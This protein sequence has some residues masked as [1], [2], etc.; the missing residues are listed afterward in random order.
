[1]KKMKSG[2]PILFIVDEV[3]PFESYEHFLRKC[4]WGAEEFRIVAFTPTRPKSLSEN[5]KNR[6]VDAELNDIEKGRLDE[7]ATQLAKNFPFLESVKNKW[8]FNE[9]NLAG[10]VTHG[11]DYY[12]IH[13]L[14]QVLIIKKIIEKIKPAQVVLQFGSPL[15]G[16]FFSPLE[17]YYSRAAKAFCDLHKIPN[18]TMNL[19]PES[20]LSSYRSS[21]LERESA[22]SIR[23][24][25][26]VN[27]FIFK[28]QSK[29]FS[30]HNSP[31]V[32]VL[33]SLRVCKELLDQPDAPFSWI[34]LLPHFSLK[35]ILN[36][37]R[38]RITAYPFSL[39]QFRTLPNSFERDWES[40]KLT[41]EKESIWNIEGINI[42][43]LI[44][45]R[46]FQLIACEFPALIS[47]ITLC[48]EITEKIK[49]DAILIDEDVTPFHKALIQVT[50]RRSIPSVVL[51]HGVTGQSRG[52][53]PLSASFFAAWG[54][55][56]KKRL[57][58]WGV[59]AN[60]I[61]VTGTPSLNRPLPAISREARTGIMKS[62]G[63]DP[64]KKV[65]LYAPPRERKIEQGLFHAK[66]APNEAKEIFFEVLDSVQK[67]SDCILI[68]KVHPG[69]NKQYFEDLLREKGLFQKRNILITESFN[70]YKLIQIADAVISF[71]STVCIEAMFFNV[72]VININWFKKG[73]LIPFGN[74]NSPVYSVERQ[75]DLSVSIEK[76]LKDRHALEAK[77]RFFIEQYCGPSDGKSRERILRLISDS[78]DRS[79]G[80]RNTEEVALSS[81]VGLPLYKN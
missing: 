40:I 26:F 42:F 66:L 23:L 34:F 28:V 48:E 35:T 1:M 22:T 2:N 7:Q 47:W 76:A 24:P 27:D 9:I 51:Q 36:L 6:I 13:V 78:L 43:K 39:S 71:Y 65:I 69:G 33:S 41:L 45:Q 49:F 8:L 61:V 79:E 72:P 53:S 46:I 17:S 57:M 5:L 59:S 64:G 3:Q 52:Y 18:V 10:L 25:Q 12:F 31:K 4:G 81:N 30:K 37:F 15:Q 77:R 73:S 19:A 75:E 54:E 80:K 21:L 56:S 29:R 16:P 60:Q 63:F 68:V 74:E 70:L 11:M 62:L 44:E 38:T 14:K 20:K 67:L 32:A 50:R 55:I 58:E